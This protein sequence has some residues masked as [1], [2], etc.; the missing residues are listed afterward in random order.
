M[1]PFLLSTP[2]QFSMELLIFYS[3]PFSYNNKNEKL[4]KRA[5]KAI[6][7]RVP[8]DPAEVEEPEADSEELAPDAAEGDTVPEAEP[9]PDLELDPEPELELL[10][11][12]LPVCVGLVVPP[13]ALPVAPE[14]SSP[15]TVAETKSERPDKNGA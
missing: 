10:V 14:E 9:E 5:P 3:F 4:P 2:L 15:V 13:V 12:P 11:V 1:L 6:S 7:G 8:S